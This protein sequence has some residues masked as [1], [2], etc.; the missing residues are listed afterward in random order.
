MFDFAIKMVWENSTYLLLIVMATIMC[1]ALSVYIWQ[2]RSNLAAKYL[3]SLA[4]FAAIWCGLYALEVA[5]ADAY[6]TYIWNK[7]KYFGVVFVPVTWIT[8]SLAF[9]GFSRWI[10]RK[11]ILFLLILPLTTLAVIWG[12]ETL[13]WQ[14]RTFVGERSFQYLTFSYAPWVLGTYWLFLSLYAGWYN[15]CR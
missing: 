13:F 5:S 14:T 1:V 15:F 3:F 11:T 9:T 12:Q 7:L 2:R 6:A 8:F 4:F 10:N